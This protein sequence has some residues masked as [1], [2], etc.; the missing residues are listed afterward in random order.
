[1]YAQLESN[2]I[3]CLLYESFFSIL[4]LI[5]TALFRYN[6]N[7]FCSTSYFMPSINQRALVSYSAKQM[8]DIVN[9]Y[10]SYPQ[11]LPH[12]IAAKALQSIDNETIGELTISTA[13]I[14]QV[15]ATKNQLIPNKEIT[16]QLASGP[17]KYLQGK[18]VFREIDEQSCE[19]ALQ[20]EFEFSNPVIA[21]AFGRIFSQLTTKMIEAFKQRAKDVYL[22]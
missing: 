15:F 2:D 22:D 13:G 3:N 10:E 6:C 14:K 1:M 17:F 9:D 11:F 21:F 5:S 20:L 4:S 12:C 18:W 7:I 8:Y 19:I 16:M